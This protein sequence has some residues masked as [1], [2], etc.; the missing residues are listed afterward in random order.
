MTKYRLDLLEGCLALTVGN[1][2]CVGLE[3]EAGTKQ[4]GYCF[5]SAPHHQYFCTQ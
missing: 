2:H 4:L 3:L 5:S 1:L